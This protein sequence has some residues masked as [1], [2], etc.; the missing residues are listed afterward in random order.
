MREVTMP[1]HASATPLRVCGTVGIWHTAVGVTGFCSCN[2]DRA[3]VVERGEPRLSGFDL[4]DK[5]VFAPAD[6]FE[7]EGVLVPRIVKK[8]IS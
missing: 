4:S 5:F 6:Q 7:G 2:R 8:C 3:V 1:C